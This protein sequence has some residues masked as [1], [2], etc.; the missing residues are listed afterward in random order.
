MISD[1][2]IKNLPSDPKLAF[3]EYVRLLREA[4]EPGID[5]DDPDKYR[6]EFIA[7]LKAFTDIYDV[8]LNIEHSVPGHKIYE[9]DDNI[10]HHLDYLTTR[11]RLESIR[12]GSLI[13]SEQIELTDDY[14]TEIHGH[15]GRVRKIVQTVEIEERLRENILKRLNSLAAEVDKARSGLVRFADA[16]VEMTSAVGEGAKNLEPAVKIMERI[17]AAFG[18][19]RKEGDVKR[20]SGGEERKLIAG[21]ADDAADGGNGTDE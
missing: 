19:A 17:G 20:I 7:G 6:N 10:I 12:G 11:F 8:G 1:E 9:Y 16:L 2:A 5:S 4:T 3:C 15:L 13:D 14:R 21:P 18:K